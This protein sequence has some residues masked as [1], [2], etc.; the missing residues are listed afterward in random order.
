MPPKRPPGCRLSSLSPLSRERLLDVS[1]KYK[2]VLYVPYKELWHRTIAT[3]LLKIRKARCA[4]CWQKNAQRIHILDKKWSKAYEMAQKALVTAFVNH[5]PAMRWYRTQLVKIKAVIRSEHITEAKRLRTCLCG[6]KL[7]STWQSHE[8]ICRAC[9]LGI[10]GTSCSCSREQ[11]EDLHCDTCQNPIRLARSVRKHNWVRAGYSYHGKFGKL[12]WA[13]LWESYEKAEQKLRQASE[14]PV[15][16]TDANLEAH[17]FRLAF[18]AG[19]V[20]SFAGKRQR[21]Q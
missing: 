16:L 1:V 9:N 2:R 13:R 19:I 5:R 4:T 18:A 12:R 8:S 10:V 3:W 17:D 20:K 11:F 6:G 15:P 14:R 7:T 21:I